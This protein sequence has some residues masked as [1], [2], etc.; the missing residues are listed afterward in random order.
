MRGDRPRVEFAIT[1]IVR[2]VT[3]A[4][5]N[6]DNNMSPWNFILQFFFK[7]IADVMGLLNIHKMTLYQ[8]Q[9]NFLLITGSALA[10]IMKIKE[11]WPM[12][13]HYFLNNLQF[14]FRQSF[15]HKF[16][17]RAAD[18]SIGGMADYNRHTQCD[19]WVKHMET[20]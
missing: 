7:V 1:H 4:W 10:Q 15:V 6:M 5:F 3:F 16:P 20:G 13:L 19:D 14:V 17:E 2:T 8:M 18:N 9:V 12:F 11:I